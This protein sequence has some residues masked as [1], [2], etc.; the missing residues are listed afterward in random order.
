[1]LERPVRPVV[2]APGAPGEGDDPLAVLALPRV[3]LGVGVVLP[4]QPEGVRD[5]LAEGAGVGAVGAHRVRALGDFGGAGAFQQNGVGEP[6]D[7]LQRYAGSS[8]DLLHG[9]PGTNAGLDL[10]WTQLALQLD[11]DLSEPGEIP[12]RGGTQLLVGRHGETLVSDRVLED[13]G[14]LTATLGDP[15]DPQRPHQRP[16]RSRSPR[17]GDVS[18]RTA[19]CVG[20]APT[21]SPGLSW[22]ACY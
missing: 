19:P 7:L 15:D 17:P 1:R 16:S 20:G 21:T 14:E 11:R 12:P 8:G 4:A 9:R 3:P 10:T 5:D 13:D 2:G 22:D 6:L 18:C